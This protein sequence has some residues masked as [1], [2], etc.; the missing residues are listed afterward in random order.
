MVIGLRAGDV[1]CGGECTFNTPPSS[2]FF[3]LYERFPDEVSA[4]ASPSA[5]TRG[6]SGGADIAGLINATTHQIRR[7]VRFSSPRWCLAISLSRYC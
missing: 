3:R 1:A 5:S 6:Q 4:T 7:R 2:H